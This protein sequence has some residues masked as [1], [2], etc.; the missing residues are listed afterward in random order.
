[1]KRAWKLAFGAVAGSMLSASSQAQVPDLLTSF[2]AGGSALGMGGALQVTG[3]DTLSSYYNP[4]GL[5]YLAKRQFG[6]NYRNLPTSNSV[7]SGTLAPSGRFVDSSGS[8]GSRNIS[9]VGFAFPLSD[10]RKGAGGVLGIAYT[11]G[12]F[13]DDQQ[14]SPSLTVNDTLNVTNYHLNRQAKTEFYTLAYGKSNAAQTVSF[15]VAFNYIRQETSVTEFGTFSDNSGSFGDPN[16]I[17][18]TGHGFGATIGIQGVPKNAPN[19]SWGI[20]YRTPVSLT[21]NPNTSDLY[22][23]IPARAMGGIAMRN[24]NVRGGKDFVVMGA[25]LGYYFDGRESNY[26]DRSNQLTGGIGLEYNRVSSTGR[27]PFRLGFAAVPSGGT[28]FAAR[29][30]VTYGLGYR[31]SDDKYSIDLNFAAPQGGGYDVSFGF[32]YR[33]EK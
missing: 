23:R 4:A 26:F 20:S 21:G 15:G 8:A 12:G 6:L 1:M 14:F 29:N 11:I 31:P 10:V 24:D 7:S 3:A 33:F 9:H 32:N 25:Q 30:A 16:A 27:I 19:T 17:S 2:D 5:G 22:G 13:M 18:D 28:G